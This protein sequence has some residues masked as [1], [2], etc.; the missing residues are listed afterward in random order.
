MSLQDSSWS[1][2]AWDEWRRTKSL[3]TRSQVGQIMLQR[4]DCEAHPEESMREHKVID[5]FALIMSQ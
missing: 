2:Q 1:Q 3:D 5:L 4:N